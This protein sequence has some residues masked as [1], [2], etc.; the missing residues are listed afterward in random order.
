MGLEF[1]IFEETDIEVYTEIMKLAF[2]D[3]SKRHL[4]E[5]SGG[6]PGYD[7]GSFLREFALHKDSVAYKVLKDD[8]PVGLIIVW[9]KSDGNNYLGNMFVHPKYQGRGIGFKMWKYIE[10][11]YDKTKSWSTE[12]P[13]FSKTNHHFYINKCGFYLVKIDNP[14]D[15][16]NESYL[17]EKKY[18]R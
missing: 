17:L 15:K 3:D 14:M 18:N 1:K 11:K 9:I 5:E 10:A 2:N 12:T 13:G 6:P 8:T 16:Y 7:D 4:N